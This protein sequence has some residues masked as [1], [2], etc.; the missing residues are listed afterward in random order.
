MFDIGFSEMM[1]IGVVA[2]IVIG[3]ERLPKVARTAGALF[4]RMQRYVADVKADIN[5]EI[6]ASELKDL[7]KTMT[8]AASSFEQSVNAQA[9]EVQEEVRKT[10][11]EFNRLSNPMMHFGLTGGARPPPPAAGDAPAQTDRRPIA[12]DGTRSRRHRARRISG[13]AG[14]GGEGRRA[15][16]KAIDATDAASASGPATPTI[17]MSEPDSFLSHLIELRDRL[18]RALIAII[19]VFVC[20]FPCASNLFDLLAHPLML[21]LP[22]GTKMLAT[23]VVTPFLIPVK[24]ALMV[25][26]AIALP[27]VLYQAWAFVAPGLYS[28]EKKFVMPLVVASTVLFFARRVVLLFLRVR[29]GV[30]VRLL[31][32]AAEHHGGARHRELLQFRDRDVPRLRRDLRS[33]DRGDPAGEAQ[34][35]DRREAAR[36]PALR[37]R[38]RVRARRGGDAARRAVAGDAR[39]PDLAALRGG[40]HRGRDDLASQVR[41]RNRAPASEAGDDY[42]SRALRRAAACRR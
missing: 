23:G 28:H 26:F 12:P 4:G 15:V 38:R 17:A 37:D 42:S 31:D 14:S 6:D 18:V 41:P 1:V 39:D 33:A 13:D 29:R 25:A 11:E 16:L 2:L 30:Q 20:V 22:E 8:E 24:V 36:D 32:R 5:R 9:A 34:H 3:P 7:K 21:A 35:G 40:N 27:Y 19:I 10:E